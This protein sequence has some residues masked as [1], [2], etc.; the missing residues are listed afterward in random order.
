MT[1]LHYAVS[2]GHDDVVALLLGLPSSSSSSNK[3][4]D[5][6]VE[7]DT[8]RLTALHIAARAGYSGIVAM[9]LSCSRI[10]VD[11]ASADG[12]TPLHFACFANQPD[13]VRELLLLPGSLAAGLGDGTGRGGITGKGSGR[14]GANP[15][16]KSGFGELPLH[17]TSYHGHSECTQYL[18]ETLTLAQAQ[19]VRQQESGS[20]K[21]GGAAAMPARVVAAEIDGRNNWGETPLHLA[22]A[23]NNVDTVE[24]LLNHGA[25]P[26]AGDNEGKVPL[27]LAALRGH[28]EVVR[29]LLGEGSVCDPTVVDQGDARPSVTFTRK[30]A[31]VTR[32]SDYGQL[33]L[34]I[35]IRAKQDE[36]VYLLKKAAAM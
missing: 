25:D 34:D 30:R 23:H 18:L 31:D 22:S 19:S 3:A 1:A 12:A 21:G 5:P 14:V 20:N 11:V 17:W 16:I 7:T 26:D 36:V 27:H 8:E 24:M 28:A 10:R 9:L 35:A 13:C 15:N 6:N 29:C 2:N 4:A 32:C 33:P